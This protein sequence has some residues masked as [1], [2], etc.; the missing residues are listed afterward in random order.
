MLSQVGARN[1]RRAQLGGADTLERPKTFDE[2][3]VALQLIGSVA[4][5]LEGLRRLDREH[6]PQVMTHLRAN[7]PGLTSQGL[8]LC[9]EEAIADLATQLAAYRRNPESS[10]FDP[11]RP[12]LPFFKTIAYRRAADRCRRSGV[13]KKALLAAE[14]RIREGGGFVAREGLHLVER[15]EFRTVVREGIAQLPPSPRAVWGA[16]ID[17]CFEFDG[18]PSDEELKDY[19]SQRTGT[20]WTMAAVRGGKRNGKEAMGEHLR[21][22]GFDI[23][24]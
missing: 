2:V 15:E 19:L 16:I 9:Y 22:K 1:W 5:Q 11:D 6:R 12:L 17:Y 3:E 8:E 13:Q 23:D 7:Y 24:W 14:Q 10:Q 20:H 21:S 18:I 4:E